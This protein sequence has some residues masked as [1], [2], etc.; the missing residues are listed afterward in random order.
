LLAGTT[1]LPDV[2]GREFEVSAT[3]AD[4]VT[5]AGTDL[6]EAGAWSPGASIVR[7]LEIPSPYGEADLQGLFTCQSADALY[8]AHPAHAPRTLTRSGHASWTLAAFGMDK[9]PFAPPNG[10]DRVRVMCITEG[11]F[12]PGAKVTLRASAPIFEA[13]HAGSRFRLSEIYLADQ[14]VSPWS[15]GEG[16]STVAGTQV[17]SNGHV[18]APTLA[19]AK[20]MVDRH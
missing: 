4:T 11:S 8:I 5:L 10:D 19:G 7:I 16:I 14:A 20:S 6:L 15:P 3:T 1:G 17:S 9:G 13:G 2:N 12:Q 18:Y